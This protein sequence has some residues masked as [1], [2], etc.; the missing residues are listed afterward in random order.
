MQ[1]KRIGKHLLLDVKN[2]LRDPI[3]GRQFDGAV[4]I[5]IVGRAKDDGTF[6]QFG[7][8]G[9]GELP[10]GNRFRPDPKKWAFG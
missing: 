8:S 5:S 6:D 3:P 7:F 4:N 9:V 10:G 2:P 1:R